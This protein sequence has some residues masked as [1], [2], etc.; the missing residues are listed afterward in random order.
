MR[1]L[2]EYN[3][4]IFNKRM[5]GWANQILKHTSY[6]RQIAPVEELVIPMLGDMISGDIHEELARSNMANCMEQMI[7]G[8]SIIAQALMYL[9]PH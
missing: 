8:A 5:Y 4:E 9:A 6:R 1:G 3:F 2:N 7:R